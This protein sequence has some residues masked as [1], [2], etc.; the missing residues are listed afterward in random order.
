MDYCKI[1]ARKMS[2][3]A[4]QSL[5]LVLKQ[6]RLESEGTLSFDLALPNEE[7]LPSFSAGAH[8]DVQIPNG[9]KRSYSIVSSSAVRN[10]WRIAVKRSIKSEGGAAWFHQQ[11]RVGMCIETSSPKNNFM[12]HESENET[13][14]IVGGIGITPILSMI[15]TLNQQ[16]RI[17]T[18]HY[19]NPSLKK[20]AFAGHLN[21]LAKQNDNV[22]NLYF[23]DANQP[24]KMNVENIVDSSHKN[25]HVYCCGP[26]RMI[27]TFL[28]A[29]Q[30]FP[31]D[32]VHFERF[33][34]TQQAA[35]EGSYLLHL[36]RDG[37]SITV[38]KGKSMLDVLLD[39]GLDIPY[40]CTQG[41]CGTCRLTVVEG[42]PDH[43]DSFLSN[44]EQKSGK[45]VIPCCSGSVS[46]TLVLDL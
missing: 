34:A 5:K 14:F 26:T 18:L 12:L 15:E 38:P 27:D 44:E 17:W 3:M 4:D 36:L 2:T 9:P 16:G 41:V 42:T 30:T 32:Q 8:I 23:S 6:I 31:S 7:P 10:Y 28:L 1:S 20:M 43:R 33:V 46:Q 13:I 35:T 24:S 11:A 25:S 19:V 21:K 37:R 40:S 22:V 29:T 39:N 45:A